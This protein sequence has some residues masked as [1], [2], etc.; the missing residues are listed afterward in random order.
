MSVEKAFK[1]FSLAREE[2]SKTGVGLNIRTLASMLDQGLE[3]LVES[4]RQPE[5]DPSRE[6]KQIAGSENRIYALCVD[7]TLWE[8]NHSGQWALHPAIPLKEKTT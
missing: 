2:I 1:E 5:K 8:M 4:M 3:T 6:I 7:G